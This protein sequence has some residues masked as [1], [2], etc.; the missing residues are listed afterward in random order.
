MRQLEFNFAPSGEHY[1]EVP[2]WKYRFT[3]NALVEE[4]D[5]KQIVYGLWESLFGCWVVDPT[6]RRSR[7]IIPTWQPLNHNGIW[8]DQWDVRFP[9]NH[10]RGQAVSPRWRY[11]ANAAF[12]GYF[13][14]IPQVARSLVASFEHFQW[15]GLDLIMKDQQFAA[16]LDDELFNDKQQF[17]FCCFTLSDA[18]G[19][20]RAWRKEFA[21][22]LM[23]EK[24]AE[25]L[26]RLA[27]LPFSKATVRA[28]YKLGPYPCS[29]N[30]YRSLINFV[31][32]DPT[33]KVFHHA[34]QIPPGNIQ[35]LERL[36]GEFLQTNI[37]NIILNDMG[38][39]LDDPERIDGFLELF[40]RD[41][42]SLFTVAPVKFK[43]AMTDSIRRVRDLEE[44]MEFNE[45]WTT[46]YIEVTEFPPPPVQAFGNLLVPLYNAAAIK[47]EGREMQNCLA[48]LIPSVLVGETYFYH[49]NGPTPA[50]VML[51]N[52]SD[53]G[54]QFSEA[55][56]VNNE[57]LNFQTEE[58]LNSLVGQLTS[59]NWSQ[60]P[61][62]KT[63]PLGR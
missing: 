47:K 32:D 58:R 38:F 45:R 2:P 23:T 35:L 61:A 36:P 3:K 53:Q 49:W 14:G 25:L 11:E 17:V 57:P 13:A 43:M 48:D 62:K 18:T 20:S 34:N 5:N 41:L 46:R 51:V 7:E 55:L 22:A 24:R 27:N 54:W 16:F 4:I 50:T 26:S 40:F 21:T 39:I 19:R 37:L 52:T 29:K 60:L 31:H 6:S 44:L 28:L 42:I 56:G 9:I 33:S 63:K 12:A 8:R 30:I 10:A 1:P 59:A 15:L